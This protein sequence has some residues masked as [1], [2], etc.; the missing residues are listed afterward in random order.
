MRLHYIYICIYSVKTKQKKKP[1]LPT[2]VVLGVGRILE[3]KLQPWFVTELDWTQLD[4]VYYL[5]NLPLWQE[6]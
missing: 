4:F 2:F 6:A 3:T 5:Q 1:S